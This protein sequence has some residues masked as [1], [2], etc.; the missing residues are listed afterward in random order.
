MHSPVAPQTRTMLHRILTYLSH[1][2][3]V[4][5]STQRRRNVTTTSYSPSVLSL[6]SSGGPGQ[7][8]QST[9]AGKA[10]REVCFVGAVNTSR[11]VVRLCGDNVTD[12]S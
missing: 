11:R 8:L 2:Q 1:A 3:R 5:H 7:L 6:H 12:V 9:E 10:I 4:E